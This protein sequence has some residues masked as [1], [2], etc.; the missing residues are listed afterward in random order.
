MANRYVERIPSLIQQIF[1][2]TGQLH[3]MFPDRPFTPDGHLVGS[4]GEVL[5]SHYYALDLLP[6]SSKKHDAKAQDG[7]LVQ[8]KAT[9]TKTVGLRH[10]P[11]HLLVLKLDQSGSFEEVYNGPGDLAWENAGKMQKNGQRP[12]SI[13][14]LV[15]LMDGVAFDLKLKKFL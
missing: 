5:A 2:L 15:K 11:E 10:Q 3:L 6:P 13:T 14:K 1:D 4:I 7:R 8:I 9:F 12:I